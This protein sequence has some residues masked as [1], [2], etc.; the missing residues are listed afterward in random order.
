MCSW[1]NSYFILSLSALWS[2]VQQRQ[3]N[4]PSERERERKQLLK[5][6]AVKAQVQTSHRIVRKCMGMGSGDRSHSLAPL[7][8]TPLAALTVMKNFS[9]NYSTLKLSVFHE[10][11]YFIAFSQGLIKA[12]LLRQSL[13]HD[14]LSVIVPLRRRRLGP[15]VIDV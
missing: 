15:L 8:S 5:L 12:F 9:P 14:S 4:W 1:W 6:T 2:A 10:Y 13:Y 3:L 7:H 11:Y